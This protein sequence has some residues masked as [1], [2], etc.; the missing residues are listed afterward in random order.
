MSSLNDHEVENKL[1]KQITDYLAPTPTTDEPQVSGINSVKIQIAERL[2]L[3]FPCLGLK[4]NKRA[5]LM[6][7]E[8]KMEELRDVILQDEQNRRET[9]VA[10]TRLETKSLALLAEIGVISVQTRYK[11][12][13]RDDF[14]DLPF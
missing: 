11:V 2:V 3:K 6:A 5:L 4:E 1:Y 13:R 10:S 9:E 7:V 14:D 12:E 8:L